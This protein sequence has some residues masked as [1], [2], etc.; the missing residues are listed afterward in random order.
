MT[1]QVTISYILFII[2]LFTI[3]YSHRSIQRHSFSVVKLLIQQ[4]TLTL[5]L[6][7]RSVFS[8]TWKCVSHNLTNWSLELDLFFQ[9]F[10]SMS[11]SGR[12]DWRYSQ[13]GCVAHW[14]HRGSQPAAC[15]A[16][17]SSAWNRLSG[18]PSHPALS[19]CSWSGGWLPRNSQA[20]LF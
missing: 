2:I 15:A 16:A 5:L 10:T 18:C 4:G 14:L 9:G 7:Q 12:A 1:A 6:C 13:G 8:V 19:T 11:G 20:M 3:N 17:V